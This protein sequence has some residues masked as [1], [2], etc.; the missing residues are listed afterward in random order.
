LEGIRKEQM[1]RIFSFNFARFAKALRGKPTGQ[2]VLVY[3]RDDADA[4]EFACKLYWV[5]TEGGWATTIPTP[6]EPAETV[7][8]AGSMIW[9]RPSGVQIFAKDIIFAG[10]AT[11]TVCGV[12]GE[13]FLAAGTAQVA[14]PDRNLTDDV[15]RLVVARKL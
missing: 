1:P 7:A 14:F 10:G 2:V 3:Q 4:Y 12:I 15:V 8:T 11:E 6:T 9:P 13:A 5:L